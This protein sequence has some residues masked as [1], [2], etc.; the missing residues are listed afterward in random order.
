MVV[1]E[2]T[3]RSLGPLKG[4][5][6][7]VSCIV[8]MVTDMYTAYWQELCI[9]K[10][11]FPYPWLFNMYHQSQSDRWV[12][13]D[14]VVALCSG[15][16]EEEEKKKK[17]PARDRSRSAM[18]WSRSSP[19]EDCSRVQSDHWRKNDGVGIGSARKSVWSKERLR[20]WR[21]AE[22]GGC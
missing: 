20:Q 22:S 13:R 10:R 6:R 9:Q 17:G 18:S 5:T 15:G 3:G 4:L 8:V 12:K 1:V 21:E 2:R 19:L 14:V 16:K 7:C 11:S